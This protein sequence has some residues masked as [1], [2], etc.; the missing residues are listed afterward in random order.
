V[1]P[2]QLK[3]FV[4]GHGWESLAQAKEDVELDLGRQV[5]VTGW[6]AWEKRGLRGSDLTCEV[7]QA[8]ARL[9]ATYEEGALILSSLQVRS[10]REAM[11]LSQPEASEYLGVARSTWSRWE[12]LG[13]VD[14]FA[15]AA[16]YALAASIASKDPGTVAERAR[17]I[18]KIQ[19]IEKTLGRIGRPPIQE[20]IATSTWGGQ[21]EF[22][23]LGIGSFGLY[24]LLRDAWETNVCTA[25]ASMNS[26]QANFC[27]NCGSTLEPTKEV[28]WASE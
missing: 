13:I 7:A 15:G 23:R 17:A 19:N 3:R 6:E 9:V 25:C 4:L 1:T 24:F 8:I 28:A 27:S 16:A 10:W 12:Q 22:A 5:E 21:G 20:V 26:V 2:Q 11:G 18:L 14:H